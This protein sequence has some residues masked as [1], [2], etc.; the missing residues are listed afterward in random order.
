M[1]RTTTILLAAIVAVL[2]LFGVAY[3]AHVFPDVADDNTHADSIEWANEAGVVLGYENGMFGP[4]DSITRGQAASMFD[5]YNDTL[6]DIAGPA[7]PKGDTGA[8]GP[9]GPSGSNGDDAFSGIYTQKA[10]A[11]IENIQPGDIGTA[12]SACADGYVALSGGHKIDGTNSSF[13]I[14]R[15]Q[16]IGTYENGMFDAWEVRVRNTGASEINVQTA[17]VCADVNV[18]PAS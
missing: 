14:L 2:G 1:K 4:E 17:V 16:P 3:A 12:T 11:D 13:D 15:S 8:T 6:E 9:S 18:A 7:G 5:R 10:V